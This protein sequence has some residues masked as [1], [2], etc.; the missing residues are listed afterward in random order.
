MSEVIPSL[1]EFKRLAR[2]HNVIP[3]FREIVVDGVT[4]VSVYDRLHKGEPYAF[5]LESVEGGD[6]LGRYSFVGQ[7]PEATFVCK[8]RQA[9]YQQGAHQRTWQVTNPLQDMKA[10]FDRF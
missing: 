10:I 1:A 9:V 4:P 5:L 2:T 3:V 7:R 8:G 6:R